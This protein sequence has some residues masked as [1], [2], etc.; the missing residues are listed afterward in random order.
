MKYLKDEIQKIFVTSLVTSVIMIFLGIFLL[1][2]PDFI[3]TTLST[4]IG[5]IV[6]VPA[7][8]SLIDYFKTKY[9]ANLIVGVAA[10]V[11]GIIFIFNPTFIS[12]IL[13][14]VLGVYFLIDGL[15]RLQYAFEMKK[16]QVPGC[17]SA[18]VSS[19][20]ILV[21][22]VLM[23]LNPFEGA[24]AIT[25]VIGIFLILHS[26]LDLYNAISTKMK[27]TKFVKKML[28]D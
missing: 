20:L 7:V 12:S 18:F 8:I 10:G 28:K 19:I 26:A 5:I 4:V 16:N 6:L 22:G 15:S 24:L 2:K 25:Q 9:M 11:M 14:F 3:L 23:I 1:C 27:V 13:P 17:V 21:L